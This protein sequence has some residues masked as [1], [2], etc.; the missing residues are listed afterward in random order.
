MK[1]FPTLFI[2]KFVLCLTLI[3]IMCTFVIPVSA[4]EKNGLSYSGKSYYDTAKLSDPR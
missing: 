3:A 4:A 2:E 1:K